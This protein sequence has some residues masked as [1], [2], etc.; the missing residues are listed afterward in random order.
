MDRREFL[1]L[2]VGIGGILILDGCGG[3]GSENSTV[4]S[5]RRTAR[6]T[7][8]GERAKEVSVPAG[9]SVLDAIKTAFSYERQAP[10]EDT[11]A[12][13]TIE[14]ISGHWRYE[15]NNIEPK[16]NAQNYL[17]TSDCSVNLMRF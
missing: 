11:S 1:R 14:G 7:L 2:A 12:L 16:V 6:I 5:E 8:N 9:S 4:S 17:I 3:G 13:T 15:A 10:L